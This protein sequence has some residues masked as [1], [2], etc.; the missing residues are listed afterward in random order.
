ML[1]FVAGN[2][3]V[4][5]WCV[6]PSVQEL[7]EA[8]AKQLKIVDTLGKCQA[9]FTPKPCRGFREGSNREGV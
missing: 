2:C 3:G 8:C 7:M 5:G 1:M 9:A 4:L 6:P